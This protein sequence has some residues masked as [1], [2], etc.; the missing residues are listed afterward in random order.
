MGSCFSHPTTTRQDDD[1]RAVPTAD[2]R[3]RYD[4]LLDQVVQVERLREVQA[5][6]GFTRIDAP[7]RRRPA[8][9]PPCAARRVAQVGWVPAVERRGEG[10]FLELREDASRGVGCASVDDHPHVDALRGAYARWRSNRDLAPDPVFPIPRYLLLHTLSHLLLRAR[11]PSSAATPRRASASASTSAPPTAPTA[12]VL[13]STAASDSEGTL[14]GLVALGDA[15]LPRTRCS[16]RPSKTP[17]AAPPT[18]SAPSTS[19]SA[20]RPPPRAPPATPACSPLRPA[21]R[22]ATG[23]STAASSSTSPTDS[24]SNGDHRPDRHSSAVGAA[25]PREFAR[26]LARALREGHEALQA[27][28]SQAVLPASAAAVRTALDLTIQGDG[29]YARG[30]L[31]GWVDALDEQTELTPVWTG[32]ES[33]GR[34]GRL[35]LAV[36]ADLID[37][38][39][40]EILLASYATIPGDTI[41]DALED[42]A[43]R[44]VGITLLLE[45]N[46]DNPNFSGRG[47][48]FPGLTRRQLAWPADERPAGASMHAKVLVVDR[49]IALVGSA[50]LTGSALERNL[51]CGLLVRGGRVPA[52]LAEHLL[53]TRGLR[54]V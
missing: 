47:D 34:H 13:L 53:A 22:Q 26:Q 35:T 23:G 29:P 31:V 9:A 51:E 30:L 12:G 27:L 21:A 25:L 36:V 15:R 48:S 42:A 50:N 40:Q 52:L 11:S 5:M 1:F 49:R 20:E 6:V 41:Q 54:E 4:G 32:P 45:R 43:D 7:D 46:A 19:P 39:R 16:T 44:G 2:V 37:E 14:G 18:R 10:I 38:A 17:D 3:P 8:A 33:E 24:L 28:R